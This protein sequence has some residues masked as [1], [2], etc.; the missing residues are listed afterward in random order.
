MQKTVPLP[1]KRKSFRG[2]MDSKRWQRVGEIFS[3]AISLDAQARDEFL[4][5]ACDGDAAL[6]AD[7]KALLDSEKD[8]TD[9]GFLDTDAMRANPLL[10]AVDSADPLIGQRLGNYEVKKRIGRGGMGNVYLA[11]RCEDFKQRVAI[12]VLKRGMDTEDFLRRF[13][14]EIRVLAALGQH[15]NIARLIDA[16]STDDGLPYFVMEHVAGKQIDDYCDQHRLSIAERLALFRDVCRAV[17]FAHQHTVIHRDLKPSNV[18]VTEDGRPKLIDF[19]IAKITAP[20]L[21]GETAAPTRTEYRAMTPEYASP[22]QVRGDSLT[23][24]TDVYSL[25]MLLFELL[26]GRRPS[27]V[28][29]TR[30]GPQAAFPEPPK[31]STVVRQESQLSKSADE[32]PIDEIA[33]NRQTAPA[34]LRQSLRGD[35]D[36]LVGMA[37]RHEPKRRYASAGQMAAD[38]QRYLDE[39]PLT[40]RSLSRAERFWRVCHR[41][42]VTVSTIAALLI[43][44]LFGLAYLSRLS[45]LLV[46]H[47]ALQSARQQTEMLLHGH[48]YYT[49]VLDDLKRA[50]PDAA[51]ELKPP[52]TFTMELFEFLNRT[53][54][55][56]GTQARMRSQ[57]PFRPRQGREPLD[58]FERAAMIDFEQNANDAYYQ[59]VEFDTQPSLRYGIA[60]RM[61]QSCC[62]CHNTHPDSTKTDW[63]PGQVRGILEV[64]KPLSDDIE[65]TNSGLLQAFGWMSLVIA[66]AFGLTVLVIR[67][68][69]R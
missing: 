12:K 60:M 36:N 2:N 57:Y 64:I 19:G 15:P 43:G 39:E 9:H 18:L 53:K 62:D 68:R 20:E 27:Q 44:T 31:P 3:E 58:K 23:T 21:G 11:T 52:A 45:T 33:R 63:Q 1:N 59:F 26:T 17:H 41:N 30:L 54:G 67:R 35:L 24:A 66:G 38:I 47:T 46:R 48:K 29:E 65:R 42:P 34:A 10:G 6:R 8:V 5:Q 14:M 69:G 16:G 22:E 40:A 4:Q 7:V 49:N 50:S 56:G 37:L 25:G 51:Q 55:R 61:E 13:R 28:Q 32:R